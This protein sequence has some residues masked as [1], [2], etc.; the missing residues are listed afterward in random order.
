MIGDGECR[1]VVIVVITD[2][3]FDRD[4]SLLI[5]DFSDYRC[6][7]RRERAKT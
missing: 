4:G 3:A 5:A 7:G 1:V 2:E 6:D